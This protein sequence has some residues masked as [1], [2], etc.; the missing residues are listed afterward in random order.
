VATNTTIRTIR[1]VAW[2]LVAL[3]AQH[4]V[5][6]VDEQV[7]HFVWPRQRRSRCLLNHVLHHQLAG[8]VAA[9]HAAGTMA[10]MVPDILPPLPEVR[11]KCLRVFGD[12]HEARRLL[13]D[14]L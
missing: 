3:V 1:N 9:A 4:L 10:F 12:L 14:S 13:E 2:A 5:V 11:A 8:H 6:G 7:V